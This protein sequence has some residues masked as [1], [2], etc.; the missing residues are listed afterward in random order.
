MAR[1]LSRRV[2]VKGS[3][4]TAAALT[5]PSTI[6][7]NVLGAND[8]LRA[9]VVGVNSRGGAHIDGLG[10][11]SGVTVAGICDADVNV[12]NRTVKNVESKFKKECKGEQDIRK[13]LDDPS[14]NIIS[15][16][17][18]NHWHSLMAIW[19]MQ[20]GKDVYCEKPVSHNVW[21][22]RQAVK[23]A[24]KYK[25][26]CQTGTQ[27]RSSRR[28][29]GEAVKFVQDGE[30][31][32]ILYAVGTCYKP[33]QGIGKL[34]KPLVIPDHI[35][36]DL[37]CGPAEK[38]D[39]FRPK[40][41]YDWH[42]DYNTG[43]GD[44]G[45]QGIHQMD[46]ARWFLGEQALSPRIMSIGGRLGYDDAGDTPNTQVAFHAY[47]KAPLIFEVRGLPKEG[48]DW[49]KGMDSYRGSGVGVIVQCEGGHVVIPN[50]YSASAVDKDGKTIK[51]WREGDPMTAHVGNFVDCVRSRKREDLNAD[52]EEGHL[53]SA[54]CHTGNIAHRLGTK[55]TADQIK[56]YVKG[57]PEYTDSYERMADHL[58]KNGIDIK[59]KTMTLGPWLEM[60]GKAETFKNNAAASKLLTREYR[61][62]YEVPDI[63]RI[64]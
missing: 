45:N 63:D 41:H 26:I 44:I 12:L 10:R 43:S 51:G 47:E 54:L 6:T 20:A 36:Y 37:W 38:R 4:L 55:M 46:I 5:I 2:F 23:A 16:A 32:K 21:E 15:I 60:D 18:P 59:G 27:S 29:I 3:V 57:S 50:Y 28:G 34:D 33:R 49:K 1:K 35:D 25:K 22:G 30:L 14:F 40:L 48:L 9:A 17:T 42:W 31:G 53:S 13:L 52:I 62:G 11:Q 58:G 24:R 7:R 8:E 64:A 39:L 19:A 61:K 56:D